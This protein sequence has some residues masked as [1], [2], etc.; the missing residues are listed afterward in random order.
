MRIGIYFC[1]CGSNI[2]EKIAPEEVRA[3]LAELPE[4]AYFTAVDFICSEDAKNALEEELREKRP[5]RIVIAACS[6]RDHEG[7]FM[8]VMAK[9][10]M[11]PYLMQ[12]VNIREQVAWVTEDATA[13]TEKAIICIKGALA[14]VKLHEPLQKTE[15]ETCPDV[16]VIGAGPAGLK[17]SLALAEAGRKVTLV[18]KTP[19]IGG[20]PVRF[21]ELFPDM[22]CAPCMLEP[23]MGEILHG[24]HS[25]N[26]ELLTMAEVTGV[27]GFYGNFLVTVQQ[28]PRYVDTHQCIGCAEC[29]AACPVSAGNPFNFN[30]SDKKAIDFPFTGSL[31]N[32][33]YLDPTLCVRKN[34]EECRACKDAC[35]MGEE[36]IDFADQERTLERRV[37]AIIVATG[38]ALYDCAAFPNL[39]YGKL[40][41]VYTSMEFERISSATGPTRGAIALADGRAPQSVAIIHCVGSLDSDH[42]GYCSGVCCQ[43]A[44]KF[45]HLIEQRLPEAKVHHFYRENVAPGKDAYRLQRHAWENHNATMHRYDAIGSL[46]VGLGASGGKEVRSLAKGVEPVSAEM[47]ILCPAVVPGSDTESLG[48]L[49]EVARDGS[50]FFQ[51]LHGRIDAA[52]SKIKG[53]YLA[54]A[55]QA[56]MEIQKAALQGMAAAGHALAGLVPGR[57]L[58]IEPINAEIDPEKCAGCRLCGT[59][60]PYK[61]ISFDA[62]KKKSE[63][64]AVLCHGC[65]TCVAACPAGAIKGNHFTSEAIMAEMRGVLA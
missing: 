45:N 8:R 49:L 31:P 28:R 58:E 42:K 4:V 6:P 1:N 57:K 26:I 52:Q 53:V 39:C 34:G 15:L 44:Y 38:A 47:I 61:A 7:T 30:M 14:R 37:G 11:N 20:H 17:A 64:N 19:V 59:V 24:E 50:G 13:A 5:D 65:G 40:P 10:G 56:P 18:E 51:E 55:C 29:I 41:D 23:V 54:G 16:L 32:A 9:A 21:E 12:M 22:E 3:A 48:K 27:A 60:C 62:E 36:L 25:E 46:Q 33:P 43:Y 35:P 2:A 63:A